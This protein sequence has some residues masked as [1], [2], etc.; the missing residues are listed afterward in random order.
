ME[1]EDEDKKI[2][3][4]FQSSQAEKYKQKTIEI[5]ANRNEI[6]RENVA[7]AN[8]LQNEMKFF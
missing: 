8:S 6:Y 5:N 1:N 4:S 2:K 7:N 3:Q